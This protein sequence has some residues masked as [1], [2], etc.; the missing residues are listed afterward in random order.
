MRRG[1]HRLMR[2]RETCS[3]ICAAHVRRQVLGCERRAPTG[4]TLHGR[5]FFNCLSLSVAGRAPVLPTACAWLPKANLWR[6]R[7]NPRKA[8]VRLRGISLKVIWEKLKNK[9]LLLPPQSEEA[10]FD[11]ALLPT[12]PGRN[13][14][15]HFLITFAL[16][17]VPYQA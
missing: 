9:H 16:S 5:G 4:S 12:G 3:I 7:T 11:S 1:L 15:G 14:W 6:E 10:E 13:G 2:R 17:T 8:S